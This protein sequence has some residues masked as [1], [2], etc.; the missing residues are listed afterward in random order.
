MFCGIMES[1]QMPP[2]K[3]KPL[4]AVIFMETRT[5]PSVRPQGM[6]SDIPLLVE[7][8]FVSKDQRPLLARQ[9]LLRCYI[10]DSLLPQGN[11]FANT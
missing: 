3:W 4:Q 5:L 7:H 1:C 10:A 6:Q 2:L 9:V 11:Y 8:C